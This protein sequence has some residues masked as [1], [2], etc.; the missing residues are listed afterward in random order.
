MTVFLLTF[1]GLMLIG[2]PICFCMLG[3]SIC[4]IFINDISARVIVEK[5]CS[6][7]NSFTLLAIPFFILAAN[8]MN[9]GGVTDRMFNLCRKWV[10]HFTGGLG[11]VNVLASVIFA[12]MSGAAVADAGGLG[13]LEL[14]A[15]REGE[16]R[17]GGCIT[18]LEIL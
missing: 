17:I 5:F 1:F 4:Y 15:M 9:N 18:R 6:G 11:H 14:K 16:L 3:S 13:Q 12:G 7:P 10:G 2:T 8:L